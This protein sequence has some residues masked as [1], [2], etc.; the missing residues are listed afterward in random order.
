MTDKPITLAADE[1]GTVTTTPAAGGMTRFEFSGED[2]REYAVDLKPMGAAMFAD[3]D[4]DDLLGLMEMAAEGVPGEGGPTTAELTDLDRSLVYYEAE[5]AQA[6]IGGPLDPAR[7][8][9]FARDRGIGVS[10]AWE[11]LGSAL[12]REY[13]G[14]AANLRGGP[15]VERA[16]QKAEREGISIGEAVLSL[17]ASSTE[18][19][20]NRLADRADAYAKKHE[21][22]Y[23]TALVE[24]QKGAR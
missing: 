8:A 2:G 15:T 9:A 7:V 24:V 18:Q 22:S 23:E 1:R 11:V 6:K 12:R 5:M 10:E 21:V 19:R 13:R 3:L 14:D 17:S 4:P 16:W 20:S